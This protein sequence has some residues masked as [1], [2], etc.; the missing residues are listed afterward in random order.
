MNKKSKST[1]NPIIKGFK[2]L[3]RV[4]KRVGDRF[5]G[6][7]VDELYWK[8]R[9]AETAKTYLAEETISRP[10]ESFM[11][12]IAKYEP[13]DSVLDVGTAAGANLYRLHKRYP[14]I[15]LFGTDITP[16]SINYGKKWFRE[17]G[18][19][20]ELCIA[21]ADKLPFPDKSVDIIY[22]DGVLV[23]I[24][25]DKIH[26]V[27]KEFFRVARKALIFHEWH[28]EKTEYIDHWVYNYKELLKGHDIE[29]TK[30]PAAA[31][32]DKIWEKYGYAIT[33]S[34]NSTA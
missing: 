25:P 26:K 10:Y 7:W 24:G 20:V 12:I 21:K 13:F 22:T 3:L 16:S 14:N 17:K 5:L 6:T 28:G 9:S 19:N 18:I 1:Q 29:L 34:L 31:G 32:G 23:C 30:M 11:R 15:K 27:L 2:K 33:L 8:F 4:I